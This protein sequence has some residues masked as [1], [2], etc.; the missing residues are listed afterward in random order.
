[1]VSDKT[2][3]VAAFRAQLETL[4]VSKDF[5]SSRQLS[6]FLR[7]VSERAFEGRTQLEQEEIA[8]KVLGKDSD[9]VATYDSSVRKLASMTR[10]RLAKYYEREGVR[11]QVIVTLPLRSYLPVYHAR[12]VPAPE[13][14]APKMRRR[15]VLPVAAVVVVVAVISWQMLAR[16]V[17]SFTAASYTIETSR[18]DIAFIGA[19]A[20]PQN[21]LLGETL[22]DAR[23]LVALLSFRPEFEAQQAGILL[24]Q[25]GDNFVR[26]G[27][28]FS[29]RN[30]IE[31]WAE[32]QAVSLTPPENL[33]FDPEGQSAR[34]VWLSIRRTGD[35]F[36]ASVSY[37]GL[38][39]R[40]VG[41]PMEFA[42]GLKNARIGIYAFN[43]RRD[44]PSARAV[45][46]HVS[47][48]YTFANTSDVE[49]GGRVQA[50]CA[51]ETTLGGW[52]PALSIKMRSRRSRCS[53]ILRT[54]SLSGSEWA[55]E[56][57]IDFVNTP[58]VMSGL[59]VTGSKGRVR[60][61]RYDMNGPSIALMHD[62]KNMY[63]EKDFRG[64]PPL[65]LRLEQSQGWITARYSRDGELFQTFKQRVPVAEI[66]TGLQA[67]LMLAT[68]VSGEAAFEPAMSVY[69]IRKEA[70]A[71]KPYR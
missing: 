52:P 41:S 50:N 61:L 58:G 33:L 26:L 53:A 9:F 29:G 20:G 71:L 22:G 59:Y 13:P 27:R 3:D 24:W 70:G 4:L 67:G 37:D 18:G 25:D 65:I 36:T 68:T 47:T 39:W 63:S 30:N 1:M 57:R 49:W 11:D 28:R 34:P 17:T 62:N 45:F 55:L 64:S 12:E 43:G 51:A 8:S 2:V 40:T 56:T 7:F 5:A 14:S 23:E 44:A 6:E 32:R 46:R 21:V 42:G 48:G 69:S 35:L 66:G 38:D 16:R 31:F 10:Q 19:D 60:L 54:D 15:W